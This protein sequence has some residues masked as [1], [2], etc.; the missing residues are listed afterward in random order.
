MN[1]PLET[2]ILLSLNPKDKISK[3]DRKF[4]DD[5]YNAKNRR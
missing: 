2:F 5:I 3:E 4:L 1:I